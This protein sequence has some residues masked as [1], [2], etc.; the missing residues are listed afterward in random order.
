VTGFRLLQQASHWEGEAN[1]ND[2]R[3]TRLDAPATAIIAVIRLSRFIVIESSQRSIRQRDQKRAARAEFRFWKS[4]SRPNQDGEFFHGSID[5]NGCP[6]D[7]RV[8][9]RHRSHFLAL[10]DNVSYWKMMGVVLFGDNPHPC[11]GGGPTCRHRPSPRLKNLDWII[12]LGGE[13]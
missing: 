4:I 1:A 11:H 7:S 6:G 3:Y 9:P 8:S 10:N 5:P 13:F 12:R 2:S